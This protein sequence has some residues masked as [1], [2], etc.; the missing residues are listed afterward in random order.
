MLVVTLP[1][2]LAKAWADSDQISIFGEQG[3]G[4][5]EPLQILVE[6]D[7]ACAHTADPVENEDT[8]PNPRF[9]V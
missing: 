2:R 4:N 3:A 8:Y 1:E 7:F 9:A 6:K 5:T